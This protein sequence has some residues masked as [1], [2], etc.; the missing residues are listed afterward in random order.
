MP[1]ADLDLEARRKNGTVGDLPNKLLRRGEGHKLYNRYLDELEYGE[2]LGFDVVSVNEHHQT[3]YGMMPS[4]DRY[5]FVA[6]KKTNKV[7][8]AI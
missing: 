1:Y 3:A 6:C 5:C 7:K 2:E 4:A 8:I